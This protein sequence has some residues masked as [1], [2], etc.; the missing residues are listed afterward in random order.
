MKYLHMSWHCVTMTLLCV[1]LFQSTLA[2]AQGYQLGLGDTLVVTVVDH[3]EF[4]GTV[5]VMPDGCIQLPI[6]GRC[7]VAGKTAKEVTEILRTGYTQ[8]LLNPEVYLTINTVHTTNV[9]AFGAVKSPGAYPLNGKV[10]AFE[11]LLAAN[12]LA[13]P[14]EECRATVLRKATK[15]RLSVILADLLAGQPEANVQLDDGDVLFIDTRPKLP[16]YIT[17]DVRAPGLYELPEGA[18][19]SQAL[20]NAQGV[21]GDATQ[22]RVVLQ[23]GKDTKF[24]DASPVLRGDPD[25]D[26]PLQKGDVLSVEPAVMAVNIA[27]EVAQPAAYTVKRDLTVKELLVLAG[28]P[29]G[30]ARLTNVTIVHSNGV[31][32]IIDLPNEPRHGEATRL[33]PG[34]LV[35]VPAALVSVRVDGEVK[36]PG[37]YRFRPQTQLAEVLMLAGGVNENAALGCVYLTRLDGTVETFD[38]SQPA[39]K[40]NAITLREGDR[41]IVPVIST[42]VAV[43]GNVR[44]PGFLL[45]DERKPYT[46]SEA[47][48]RAGG[49]AEGSDER[50]IMVVRV[51]NGVAEKYSI[52]M[53]K[54]IS[55]GDPQD[56]LML[57][58]SDTVYVPKAQ[59]KGKLS[60]NELVTTL[61]LVSLLRAV[62]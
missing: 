41:I 35:S 38:V 28:G 48:L 12:G 36:L 40:D 25:V 9:F 24:F 44:S 51:T 39:N 46:V 7:Q 14:L 13:Q 43:T 42:R 61:S 49:L 19:I 47:V 1:V 16:V 56:N 17:G 8:R 21:Q 26:M 45:M 20:A 30:A 5:I 18:T 60:I 57:K 34:D 33:Q 27:G 37:T 31:Q 4:G 2:H 6:L 62:F 32:E 54:L 22:K 29:T 23:R 59:K 58:P 11:L 15:E 53:R 50:R 52:D 10:G 3:P 55:S